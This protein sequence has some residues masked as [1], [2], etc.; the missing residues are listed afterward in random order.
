MGQ[1]LLHRGACFTKK[2][3]LLST[4]TSITNWGKGYYKIGLVIQYKVRQSLLQSMVGIMSKVTLLQT[5]ATIT[6][7]TSTSS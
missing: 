7:K 2:A 5:G 4:G 3:T 6:K 1:A